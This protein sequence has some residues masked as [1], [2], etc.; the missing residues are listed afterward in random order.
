[1]PMS[2]KRKKF[3]SEKWIWASNYHNKDQIV[4]MLFVVSLW[5]ENELKNN[6]D[7]KIQKQSTFFIN[8]EVIWLLMILT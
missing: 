1:M 7:T 4:E 8:F 3:S 2:T 6:K 5:Y